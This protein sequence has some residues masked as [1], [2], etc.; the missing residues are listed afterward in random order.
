MLA[1]I[2]PPLLP[3]RRSM[4]LGSQ[5]STT[6]PSVDGG[7]SARQETSEALMPAGRHESAEDAARATDVPAPASLRALEF[8]LEHGAVRPSSTNRPACIN[9]VSWPMPFGPDVPDDQGERV[10]LASVRIFAASR[11]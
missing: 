9:C 10:L 7:L 4:L 5:A 8:E 1:A 2:L 3:P 6:G 11:R